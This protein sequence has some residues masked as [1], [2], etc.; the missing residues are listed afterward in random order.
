MAAS[1]S[2]EILKTL[3]INTKAS[4][5]ESIPSSFLLP[6]YSLHLSLRDLSVA[7]DILTLA[8]LYLKMSLSWVSSKKLFYV[9][10]LVIDTLVLG[11][12]REIILSVY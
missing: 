12:D 7:L 4:L 6:L 1:E 10:C 8:Q 5:H 2:E 3:T 11:E 9:Q